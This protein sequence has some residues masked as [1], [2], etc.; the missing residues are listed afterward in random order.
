MNFKPIT[1]LFLF[2]II[3]FCFFALIYNYLGFS[4]NCFDDAIIPASDFSL[5]IETVSELQSRFNDI[6]SNEEK[7]AYLTFDDGPTKIA[8]PAILDILK[9][10]DINATFF[11]IGYRV[12]EFPDIVKR[13]YDE[14]NFIANHGY[15]HNNT[16]LYKS[17][18]SFLK[19]ISDTDLAISNAIGIDNYISHVFRFPNG[20][21]SSKYSSI[22]NL[23]KEYL[24]DIDYAY[25]DWNALNNDS[26]KKC[27][28]YQLL[29]NLK[30]SCKNKK[31]LVILMHDTCDVSKSYQV[32]ED[33]I[34]Y[35][36]NEGYSFR[37]LRDLL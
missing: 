16:K 27:S 2:F 37:T 32:L 17:K 26:I 13:A 22:K 5:S 18:N 21:K 33:S 24:E 20:S 15:S 3:I 14:G 23:C 29:E 10:N 34:Q 1:Y 35:L 12:Y 19:E 28:N 36:K 11:V 4:H 25:V 8:T 30:S 9:K 31:S 7:I 6:Y